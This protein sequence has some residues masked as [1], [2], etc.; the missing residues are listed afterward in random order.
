MKIRLPQYTALSVLLAA[1]LV[2][3][4]S[5]CEAIAEIPPNSPVTPLAPVSPAD[6]SD[7]PYHVVFSDSTATV[8]LSTLSNQDVY[9][10]KINKSTST[11]S[12]TNTGSAIV[13]SSSSSFQQ[14]SGQQ[15]P[16]DADDPP[17][18]DTGPFMDLPRALD[19]QPSEALWEAERFRDSLRS[20]ALSEGAPARQ[21]TFAIGDPKSFWVDSASGHSG[22]FALSA[23]LRAQGT[24][25]NVWVADA[26]Y[27]NASATG[28]SD[29]KINTAQAVA[30]KDKFDIIYPLETNL[31]GY[32]F[33]GGLASSDPNYGGR[34]GD[35]RIQIFIYRDSM[36]G[37]G[38]YFWSKDYFTQANPGATSTTKTNEAEIFY[39]N[40]NWL[41]KDN[42]NFMYST[43]AHE[44]QHMINFN[45]KYVKQGGLSAAVW[46]NEMLSMLAEDILDP[47]IGVAATA[48]GHPI[49]QR[50]PSFLATYNDY[51]L[52]QWVASTAAVYPKNYAFGAYLVR[53]YGGPLLLQKILAN[54]KVD[55]DSISAA[56]T[57]IK[58]GIDFNYALDRYGEALIFNS[59]AA[60]LISFNH[61]ITQTVNGSS[62]SFTGFDI[63]NMTR[64]PGTDKGPK[65]YDAQ[66]DVKAHSVHLQRIATNQS[67][68]FSVTLKKPVSPSIAL[69]IMTRTHTN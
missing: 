48:D 23:T 1:A 21:A 53:N 10:V 18:V 35:T 29:Y 57:E 33:G 65:S 30:L 7:S 16:L 22:W 61:S 34:D 20:T 25:C 13:S 42:P 28:N 47:L 17:P 39:L 40:S 44:F 4:F 26:D 19:W 9:L 58:P 8:N 31:F 64:N 15:A 59:N 6:E 46:Y 27:D 52:E 11:V 54:N 43:L 2:S 69:Y 38:G 37:L 36:E 60:D 5:A 56:L 24:Y 50:M 3:G 12:A 62:Y 49:Q 68:N 63:W 32:E 55:A 67:G 51:G 45:M 41:D 14:A 66:T